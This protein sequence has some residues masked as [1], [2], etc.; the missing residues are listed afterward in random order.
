MWDKVEYDFGDVKS[1]ST[2]TTRFQYNGNKGVQEIEP[3]CNCVGFKFEDN[4]L[5]VRWT[6]KKNVVQPYQ[7]TKIIMIIYDDNTIDE[8][9]L[10]ANIVPNDKKLT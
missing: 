7:S 3:L 10:K 6:T 2:Q 9:T 1:G 8:I 4:L 5:K